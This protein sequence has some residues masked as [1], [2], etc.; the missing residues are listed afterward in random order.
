M[1]RILP[2]ILVFF[3]YCTTSLAYKSPADN[4]PFIFFIENRGQIIDQ[5]HRPRND[6]DFKLTTGEGVNIFIG[7]G[8]LHYQFLKSINTENEIL[9]GQVV[10]DESSQF[11]I[12]TSKMELYRMDVELIGA[13]QNAEIIKEEGIDY[14]ENYITP[15]T[16]GHAVSARGYSRIIYRDI[17]P[18]IDWVIYISKPSNNKS[19]ERPINE[20]KYDFVVREGGNPNLI[21]IKYRGHTELKLSDEGH[22]IAVTPFGSITEQAPISKQENGQLISSKFLLQGDTLSYDIGDYTGALVID[23]KLAW[24]TYY[25]GYYGDHIFDMSCDGNND[26]YICGNTYSSS[27]IATIGAHKIYYEDSSDVYLVKFSSNGMR[28]WATY[29]GTESLEEDCRLA[30][31]KAGNVY[32]TGWTFSTSGLASPGAFQTSTNG[33]AHCFLAKFNS[34]GNRVWGTYYGGN[35]MDLPNDIVVDISG[36]I[37]IGGYT[38]SNNGISTTGT[39]QGT[40]ASSS[41]GFLAKFDSSGYRIWGTYYGGSSSDQI[42]GIALD[43]S[44]YVY[45]AGSTTSQDKITTNGAHSSIHNGG[46]YDGFIVKLDS[47]GRRVWGTYYGGSKIDEINNIIV[48]RHRDVIVTGYTLS[49][50]GIASVGSHQQVLGGDSSIK[51]EHKDAFLAKFNKDG[52]VLWGTYYGAIGEDIA[53]GLAVDTI[54]DC[55]Y[56]TGETNSTSNISMQGVYQVNYGG[57]YRDGF[58]VMFNAQGARL[59]GTYIG[60]ADDDRTYQIT[61]DYCSDIYVAGYAMSNNLATST[62]HQPLLTKG[63]D[64][65]LLKFN[66][67]PSVIDTISGPSLLCVGTDI[68]LSNNAMGGTWISKTGNVS[69]SVLGKVTGLIPGIDTIEYG[70]WGLCQ[71]A[72][73]R[74]VIVI[75]PSVI[76]S[77]PSHYATTAGGNAQF[78][79]SIHGVALTYRWQEN[80]GTGFFDIIDTGRYVGS[81]TN[82]LVISD[83]ILSHHNYKYRCLINN[84]NCSDTSNEV[85]IYVWPLNVNEANQDDFLTIVPN[86]N[87]GDFLLHGNLPCVSKLDIVDFTGRVVYTDDAGI[88][89]GSFKK[90]IDIGNAPPGLYMLRL[91][92]DKEVLVRKL[93]VE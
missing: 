13:S 16:G 69:I 47:S 75:L 57:G 83:V 49:K 34:M 6:V 39:H 55:I 46:A 23:P 79:V 80:N 22:L 61:S 40:I 24:S 90:E 63:S 71:Q 41:D 48:D 14:Y 54:T 29:Y 42:R 70:F 58:A 31:D 17:Y 8:V 35:K 73:T 60:G 51:V 74:K 26:I 77:Q 19:D 18:N 82:T 76:S 44:G 36:N 78:A 21:R 5:Y 32:I 7:K 15:G 93:V 4:N 59:W 62:A 87:N 12:S 67:V 66:Y 56:I 9:N 45:V 11:E 84:G 30:V 2:F 1:T 27:N 65:L 81:G 25:G 33:N 68:Q 38:N 52:L 3:V 92:T 37:Y 86:P 72:I 20:L 89:A 64:G 91:H 50:S 88:Q 85:M 43:D 10:L 53:Y 28:L